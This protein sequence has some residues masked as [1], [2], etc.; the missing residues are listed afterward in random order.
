MALNTTKKL[1]GP[2]GTEAEFTADTIGQMLLLDIL[3][4]LKKM[5]YQLALMTDVTI[6]NMEDSDDV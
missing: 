1:Q 2:K 6:E 4:E 3:K 5:N